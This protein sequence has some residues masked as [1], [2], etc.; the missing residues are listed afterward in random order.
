M[1]ESDINHDI[2]FDEFDERINPPTNEQDFDRVVQ[3]ALSRRD[4]LKSVMA[5]GSIAALGKGFGSGDALAGSSRAALSRFAF[6]AI[7]ANSLDAITV[8]P[9]FRADI[10][11][12]WGD[13]SGQTV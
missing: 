12:R 3:R 11:A 13:L 6:T 7:D 1:S 4:V 8:P 5:I 2:D 9:G 10:V